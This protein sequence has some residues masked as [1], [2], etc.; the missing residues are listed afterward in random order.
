[1][2]EIIQDEELSFID[3]N[4]L[5]YLDKGY[6]EL[7]A[8]GPTDKPDRF[9]AKFARGSFGKSEYRSDKANQALINALVEDWHTSPIEA[10]T[11]WFR[12]KMPI[13]VMRQHVRHRTASLNELSLRYQEH[14]GEY[15]LPN[16]ERIRKNSAYNK[17]GSGEPFSDAVQQ[18]FVEMIDNQSRSQWKDYKKMIDHGV[19]R[20]IAR[21]VLGTNFYTVVYWKLDA[22]NL[23]HYLTLRTDHH[24]QWEIVQLAKKVEYFYKREFPMLYKAWETFRKSTIQLTPFDM[25]ILS[26]MIS[27]PGLTAEEAYEN[28]KNNDADFADLVSKTGRRLNKFNDKIQTIAS[29]GKDGGI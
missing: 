15:Y 8:A 27:S 18:T 16:P 9:A 1:M 11:M 19:S 23:M 25:K 17:Q 2:S 21:C 28:L 7:L 26:A 22:H 3:E 12:M 29:Y 6:V 13:F 10:P 5:S 24:A 4:T 14:N 20:E